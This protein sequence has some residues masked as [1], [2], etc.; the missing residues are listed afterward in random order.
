MTS[1]D[2]DGLDATGTVEN[3]NMWADKLFKEDEDKK[4][5]FLTIVSNF[6]LQ[7]YYVEAAQTD[8]ESSELPQSKRQKLRDN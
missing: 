1:N 6:V 4:R 7:F 2:G 3:L 8:R 5:A